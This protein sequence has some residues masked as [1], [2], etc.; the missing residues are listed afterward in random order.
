MVLSPEQRRA[1]AAFLLWSGGYA[2]AFTLI[3]TVNLIYQS[4]VAHL[5]PLQLVLVGTTL[6]IVCFIAQIPTGVL[7]DVFS[8]RAAIAIG[9]GLVGVGFIVEGLFP[10]FTAIL[11]AQIIWGLG[12]TL[13]AGA[14]GAWLAAELGE[15]QLEHVLFRAGQVGT[16]VGLLAIPASV[17]L[18]SVRL[19]V[20][21]VVGGVLLLALAL[22][23]PVTMPERAFVPPDRA[24]Q[25]TW[26]LLRATFALGVYE[27]RRSSV[28]GWYFAIELI[29][30]LASEG[31]DRLWQPFILT[32]FVFPNAPR[33]TPVAWIGFI[34]FGAAVVGI[35]A[36]LLYGRMLARVRWL[37]TIPALVVLHGARIAAVAA[38]ALA[39]SLWM[40]IG[41]FWVIGVTQVLSGPLLGARL[42]RAIPEGVRATVLSFNGQ[43]NAL[44]Q[45]AGGPGIGAVGNR[46]LRTAMLSIAVLL[47]PILGLWGGVRR[48]ETTAV[49]PRTP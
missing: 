4:R 5:D 12:A 34:E 16:V 19:N 42:A 35:V 7:A 2:F 8:R 44:G 36:S 31:W 10:T 39:G 47:A 29:F 21:V 38:F 25:T 46:S 30:G 23:V 28:L 33:L 37:H 6:E 40:A 1:Y 14:D 41:T 3:T 15:A 13:F 48:G 24:R 45:I 49:S 11:V 22:L 26:V 17:A 20:P 43:V 9:T 32:S 27:V 18:A